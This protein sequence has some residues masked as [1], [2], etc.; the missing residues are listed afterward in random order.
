MRSSLLDRRSASHDHRPSF[1]AR[2][3]VAVAQLVERFALRCA[4]DT[5][6][7]YV[8]STTLTEPLAWEN[9][10]LLRGDVA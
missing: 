6:P 3:L 2:S 5:K 7:K 10:H 1:E 9:S 8:A 4:G